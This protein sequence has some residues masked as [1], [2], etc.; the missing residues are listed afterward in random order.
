MSRRKSERIS[1]I[2]RR[3]MIAARLRRKWNQQDLADELKRLGSKIGTRSIVSKIESGARGID[4]D[5]AFEI[6]AALNCPP[7]LLFV[8]PG[9][10]KRVEITTKSRIHP[11]LAMEWI[12][13][14]SPLV[15]SQRY[16]IDLPGWKREAIPLL[17]HDRLRELQNEAQVAHAKRDRKAERDALVALREHRK[18]ME[19]ADLKPPD[20]GEWEQRFRAAGLE[21]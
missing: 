21:I 15:D 7:P 16:V 8:A 12:R 20:L 1:E 3:Q 18:A 4:I 19:M 9:M 6:A 11:H 17:M 2:F 13:A 14:Q 5:D 10:E